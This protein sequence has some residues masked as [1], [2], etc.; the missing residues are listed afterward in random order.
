MPLVF[1]ALSASALLEGWV[2]ARWWPM[3]IVAGLAFAVAV[4]TWVMASAVAE[5]PLTD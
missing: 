2:L 4:W 3:S 1:A 5:P